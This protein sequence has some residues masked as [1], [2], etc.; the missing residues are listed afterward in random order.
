MKD[1]TTIKIERNIINKFKILSAKKN[2]KRNVLI[3]EAL[4]LYLKNYS[5]DD[6]IEYDI[7]YNYESK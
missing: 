6:T 5:G 4:E 1:F 3:K 7:K 2:I